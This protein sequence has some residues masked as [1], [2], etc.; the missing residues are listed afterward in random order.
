MESDRPGRKRERWRLRGEKNGTMTYE[1]RETKDRDM[2]ER[3]RLRDEDRRGKRDR[4]MDRD[5]EKETE[6]WIETRK[7]RHRDG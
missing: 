7:E 5:Q 1:G 4:G 3:E 2:R 6:G